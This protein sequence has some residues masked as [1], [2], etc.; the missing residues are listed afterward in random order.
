MMREP[1]VQRYGHYQPRH[2]GVVVAMQ[3]GTVRAPERGLERLSRGRVL[4][5]AKVNPVK[6]NKSV[7][8]REKKGRFA[9]YFWEFRC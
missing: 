9:V 8:S 5:L 7:C 4:T 6:R 1:A 3:H 2:R